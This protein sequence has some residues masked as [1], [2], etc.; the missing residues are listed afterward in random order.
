MTSGRWPLSRKRSCDRLSGTPKSSRFVTAQQAAE[1]GVARGAVQMLVHRGTLIRA[2]HGVYR[3]PRFP[4]SQ[5]DPYMLAVLWTRVP[6]ACLSHETAL[7]AYEIS[8]LNPWQIHVTVSRDRRLR[9][10]G[11]DGYVI[12]Y[13]LTPPA[14]CGLAGGNDAVQPATGLAEP[15][16]QLDSASRLAP[17]PVLAGAARRVAA[18]AARH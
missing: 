3:F 2:A 13:E 8:D 17:G 4:V 10:A 5:Y 15:A 12:H 14:A 7:A 6:E 18:V 1:H 11:G 16:R 9:R